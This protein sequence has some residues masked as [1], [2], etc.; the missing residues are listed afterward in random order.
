MPKDKISHRYLVAAA[1]LVALLFPEMNLHAATT[2]TWD[3]NFTV[4]APAMCSDYTSVAG[5]DLQIADSG[6]ITGSFSDDAGTS[7]TV[8]G[9]L[10]GGNFS[11]DVSSGGKTI[12][13]A[14]GTRSVTSLSVSGNFTSYIECLPGSGPLTGTFAG[15]I[16][17][18]KVIQA[19]KPAPPI[20]PAKQPLPTVPP[21]QIPAHAPI[22]STL[23]TAPTPT[24]EERALNLI[25]NLRDNPQIV[26]LAK[27]VA[28]PVS[29]TLGAAS[30][31]VLTVTAAQSSASFAF[32]LSHFLRL[33]DVARFYL[34]AFLRFEKKRPWGRVIDKV[35]G[36]PIPGAIVEIY[37]ADYDK[38]RDKQLTD[39]AGRFSG[40]VGTGTYYARVAQKG[41]QTAESPEVNIR[42]TDKLLNLEIP[43]SPI[44]EFLSGYIRTISIR[45][46]IKNMLNRLNP[47]FLFFGTASSL[48]VAV[49]IPTYGNYGLLGV[50]VVLGLMKIYLSRHIS[51]S[52]GSIRDASTD[53][54]LPLAVLRIFDADRNWLLATKVSDSLGRYDF[55][56]SPGNYYMTCAKSG[57]APSRTD[58]FRIKGLDAELP[59][60]TLRKSA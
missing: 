46:S 4:N 15:Q 44:N 8:T 60:L 24:F 40:L 34:L 13:K 59:D 29:I 14:S 43:L 42:S 6:A 7:G 54:P 55:L 53:E 20:L 27:Q 22:P 19:V 35:S 39:A 32:N 12:I 38:M 3:V 16:K 52:F 48:S 28:L 45:N 1:I 23:P 17:N 36:T 51:R 26:R 10:T 33:I 5:S 37:N 9:A 50:Y 57:Y 11:Y 47:L 49:I 2:E 58:P 25:R 21:A 30:A 31:G 41:Y 56:L 18:I